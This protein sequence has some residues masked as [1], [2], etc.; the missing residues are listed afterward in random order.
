MSEERSDPGAQLPPA[1]APAEPPPAEQHG[2]GLGFHLPPPAQLPMGRAV[3][4][5]VI[6][7]VVLGG[8]FLAGWLPRR[9]ARA[10]LEQGMQLA[11]GAK[12]RVDVVVPAVGSS[13]RA[14]TLPGSV[15]ALQET[16]VYARADGYVRRW[17]V[18][19]GDKVTE[20]QLLAELDTPEVDRQLEQARAQLVQAQAAIVQAKA[21]R[22]FS[23][24]NLQRYDTL[25]KQ[26]LSAPADLDQRKAQADVDQ[27]NVQVAQA[28]AAAMEANVRRLGQLKAF[29]RVTAPFAGTVTVRSIEIGSLVTAG[30]ATPLFKIAAIDPARV[31]V[32]VPQDVAPGVRADVPAKVSVREYA[33]R[34]FEGKVTRAADELDPASRT[35]NT[36][37]RVPN[38]DGALIAGMYAEVALTLPLSHRVL[39]IPSTAIMNDAKGQRVAVV[40]PDD[41]LH[42]APVVVERDNG[43]TIDIA[44]GIADGA[45]VVKLGSTELVEGRA[46]VVAK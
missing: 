25:T 29:A 2:E 37:V 28:N 43:A 3:V 5:G 26:G 9:L 10:S 15:Q 17:H 13:D 40:G 27:A 6:A 4:I 35:M 36:E 38:G 11:E 31:F 24:S 34:V 39:V 21:N 42:I 33:G 22:D 20:G 45:R 41:T 14:L 23:A 1:P 7:A 32:Q 19:I 46:V 18:D 16:I 30:N 12:L 8:A 44:S